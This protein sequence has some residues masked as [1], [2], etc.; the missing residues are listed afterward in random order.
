VISEMMW[1][2]PFDT[3]ESI[4]E[5]AL[6][7]ASETG[8]P[9]RFEF[10]WKLFEAQPDKPGL[11]IVQMIGEVRR[12]SGRY[13]DPRLYEALRYVTEEIVQ[14]WTVPDIVNVLKGSGTRYILIA[15]PNTKWL[16][17]V[18]DE[19]YR[20]LGDS[21]FYSMSP[22]MLKTCGDITVY[23][24]VAI[25]EN[26][27]RFRGIKFDYAFLEE[28]Q[29]EV[30]GGNYNKFPYRSISADR[31]RWEARQDRD[32]RAADKWA[33]FQ[34]IEKDRM[35]AI[36][37]KAEEERDREARMM[38]LKP[39]GIGASIMSM[40]SLQ[41]AYAA[42]SFNGDSASAMQVSETA[43]FTLNEA[44]KQLME[45]MS[46]DLKPPRMF[47]FAESTVG[48]FQSFPNAMPGNVFWLGP[49]TEWP[50]PTQ[51]IDSAQLLQRLQTIERVLGRHLREQ[52][53]A[54]PS[55]GSVY[56]SG[57]GYAVTAFEI[58]QVVQA[59]DSVRGV[60]IPLQWGVDL[61]DADFTAQSED[62]EKIVL[63]KDGDRFDSGVL[64]D[65][66]NRPIRKFKLKE[67][68]A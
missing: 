35:A 4:T 10:D 28:R 41:D 59:L 36:K 23:F 53:A 51:T 40:K 68:A 42:A 30:M 32:V 11:G 43:M 6:T 27:D 57:P 56:A 3:M 63:S 46:L 38:T 1:Q 5:R 47:G 62:G 61:G 37:A 55:Q 60:P 24:E 67:L 16:R 19:I 15:G 65:P 66:A 34:E 20:S 48:G 14:E 25:I 7:R 50:T 39:R 17:V 26:E 54:A 21:Y 31:A 44:Q 49:V 58:R 9:Q 52:L 22:R 2:E 13:M 64:F 18:Q 29:R 45:K 33:N 12:D 8:V